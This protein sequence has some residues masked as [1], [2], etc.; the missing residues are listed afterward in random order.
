MVRP[1]H[2]VA[3]P[4]VAGAT[5]VTLAAAD[6]SA[7]VGTYMASKAD[8]APAVLLLHGNGSSRA[9]F[10]NLAPWLAAHGYAT[11]AIDFRG[12][13][14]SAQ[15]AR[16]F[17][18]FEAR[19]AKAAF[20]WLKAKQGGARIGIVGTS[21]G[22]ASALLGKDGPLPADAL[23]LQAVYPDMRRAIRN[24]I[25]AKAGGVIAKVAEPLLSFQSRPRFGVWPDAISPV[26]ALPVYAGPV[27]IIGG[28]LDQY[29]PPSESSQMAHSARHLERLWL[30]EGLDHE[31][32]TTLDSSTYR[33]ALLAYFDRRL[34]S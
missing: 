16:S 14:E 28:A 21:L 34:R 4:L 19:D 17:G 1:Q 3:D 32:V 2:H 15:V 22:G 33:A 10:E 6:G 30:V 5:R 29:T 23:V 20:D 11:L 24:R 8:R 31:A 25:T 7:I 12:H 26:T 18:L 27:M 9:Q 13:G